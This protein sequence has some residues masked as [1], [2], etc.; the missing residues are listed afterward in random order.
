VICGRFAWLGD[1]TLTGAQQAA[2]PVT[3]RQAGALPPTAAAAAA[4]VG[5]LQAGETDG[6]VARP[7]GEDLFS[8]LQQLLFGPPG[9]NPQQ[10]QQQYPVS[11]WWLPGNIQSR[12]ASIAGRIPVTLSDAI[13]GLDDRNI[14]ILAGAVLHT[15][16]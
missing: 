9:H 6:Q 1:G 7:A 16:G 15:S 4:L 2:K 12:Y 14:Q 10:V 13:T 8:R 3:A 5:D 11:A